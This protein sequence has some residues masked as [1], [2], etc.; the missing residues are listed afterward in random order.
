MKKIILTSVIILASVMMVSAQTN[1]VLKHVVMFGW[2]DGTDSATIKKVVD[3]FLQLPSQ[4]SL[5]KH[6]EWGTNNSPEKL[7][8]GLT[9]CF[10]LSFASEK[11]RD[12][13]LVHHAHK[14][15]VAMEKPNLDKVTVFDYWATE[16]K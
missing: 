15:F 2:K 5:I 14:L 16:L 3:A 9:H 13:Y 12:D 10:Q 6:F 8:Q 7:N 1:K 4:I 11:D